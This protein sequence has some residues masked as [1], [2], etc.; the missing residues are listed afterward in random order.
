MAKRKLSKNRVSE[1]GSFRIDRQIKSVGIPRLQVSSGT[2][3]AKEARERNELISLLIGAKD[4]IV[5]GALQDKKLT[6]PELWQAYVE[7]DQQLDALRTTLLVKLS[8]DDLNNGV[9]VPTPENP[10]VSVEVRNAEPVDGSKSAA[11]HHVDAFWGPIE[12]LRQKAERAYQLPL[13]NALLRPAKWP[14][15]PRQ[16]NGKP[17]ERG[18]RTV[19]R[20]KVSLRALQ[21]VVNLCQ[22]DTD[23]LKAIVSVKDESL[24]F[25]LRQLRRRGVAFD[26]ALLWVTATEEEREEL[27]VRDLRIGDTSLNALTSCSPALVVALRELGERV[28][29][30]STAKAMFKARL[31]AEEA[32]QASEKRV[33]TQ[34]AQE[35]REEAI[36]VNQRLD[37][38]GRWLHN[39]ARLG[40]LLRLEKE[41]WAALYAVWGASDIDWMQMQRALMAGLS[42]LTGSEHDP[43][44]CRV[45]ERI[46]TFKLQSRTLSITIDQYRSM[47]AEVSEYQRAVLVTITVSGLRIEEYENLKAEWLDHNTCTIYPNGDKTPGS[48]D[49]ITVAPAY[50]PFVV[51]A[52]PA[53]LKR[54]AIRKLLIKAAKAAGIQPIRVHDLRHCL[55]HFAAEGGATREELQAALRHRSARMT[56]IYT[57]RPKVENTARAMASALGAVD[58]A[59]LAQSAGVAA[60][61][62]ST[63]AP[64]PNR[65]SAL[66][67]LSR[68]ALHRMVWTTPIEQLAAGLGVSDVAV[69]KRCRKLEIPTPPRG[70]WQRKAKGYDVMAVPALPAQSA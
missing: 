34:A 58:A 63:V 47:L 8:A 10:D 54:S 35:R 59:S 45:I 69:H 19:R 52:V 60:L 62:P 14:S 41:H 56:E 6:V 70:Y 11:T 28:P 23:Q 44:R 9:Y 17:V 36:A 13:W 57:Q 51:Q 39:N 49:A 67:A 4:R 22:L 12:D 16:R 53:V 29:R 21:D 2:T 37:E 46:P 20:Y 25:A 42:S 5:L 32:R 64:V 40:E 48:A 3:N 43:L 27:G 18:P 24:F 31:G 50:W 66:Q 65:G 68:E 26:Q 15:S 61:A 30:L 55:G 38:I 1:H 33:S 7:A